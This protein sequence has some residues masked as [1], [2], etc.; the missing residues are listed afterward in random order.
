MPARQAGNLLGSTLTCITLIMLN[1]YKKTAEPAASVKTL[2][3]IEKP[4]GY[5]QLAAAEPCQQ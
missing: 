1:T 2:A 5:G 4:F 3:A